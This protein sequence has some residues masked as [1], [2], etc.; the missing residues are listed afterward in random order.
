[1]LPDPSAFGRTANKVMAKNRKKRIS[2]LGVLLIFCM[3]TLMCF[4]LVVRLMFKDGNV[5]KFFGTRYCYYTQEDMGSYVPSGS[6]VVIEEEPVK[7]Q[8]IILYQDKQGEYRIAVASLIVEATAASPKTYY[9]T[10]AT[11]AVAVEATEGDIIGICT[12][13]SAELG[14]MVKFLTSIAGLIIGLFIPC[15]ILLIYLISVLIAARESEAEM[16]D[17]E[18]TD[19][20]FVKSIQR[21][22]QKIAERDAERRAKERENQLVTESLVEEDDEAEDGEAQEAHGIERARKMLTDEEIARLEEEESARRAERIAAV[23]SHMEQRRQTETPDGVPLYTTEIITKT[24][25][26][27]IPKVGDQPLTKSPTAELKPTPQENIPRLTATGHIQIPTAEQIAEE[28]KAAE[29]R[30]NRTEEL[31]FRQTEPKLVQNMP[32]PKAD[33]AEDAEAKKAHADELLREVLNETEPAAETITAEAPAV[34]EAAP[35]ITA[36]AAPAPKKKK[37]K[38]K[39]APTVGSANFNDLM[40]FLNDEEKKLK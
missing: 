37:K 1:M 7:Q 9:L 25:T 28:K 6:L 12:N 10:T 32:E 23:R 20:A 14:V 3:V 34:Q 19:L 33:P 5:P 22:Q 18:D 13:R 39:A 30:Y 4:T 2:C 40:A 31:R 15:V 11:N 24:H 8:D 27:S 29:E 16:L 17:D 21:K 36:E 35:E 38:K 26:L